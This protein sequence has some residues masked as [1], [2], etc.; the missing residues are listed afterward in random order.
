M[1]IA[2]IENILG[3]VVR[4]RRSASARSMIQLRKSFAFLFPPEQ[5]DTIVGRG[6]VEWAD[7]AINS[8]HYLSVA[9]ILFKKTSLHHATMVQPII[10][11]EMVPT[12]G[13][14]TRLRFS[15]A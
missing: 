9:S 11:L 5:T 2:N 12:Q 8:M 14:Y 10:P 13:T 3:P 6:P 1:Y 4:R 7:P 15:R